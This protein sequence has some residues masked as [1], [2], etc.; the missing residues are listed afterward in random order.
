MN[1]EAPNCHPIS[2]ILRSL[3]KWLAGLA[4]VALV[5]AVYY[6]WGDQLTLANL[7]QHEQQ[8]RQYHREHPALVYITA[9]SVYVLITGLSIP[10][11]T[12]M[13][14]AMAWYFRFWRAL[15]LVSFA[16]TAGATV[17]FL[18]SRYLFRE[19]VQRRFG[20]RCTAFHIALQ[21]EGAFY[22]FTLRLIP[23]VPFFVINIVM[24]L[25]PLRTRTFWWVSQLGMLPGTIVY[26]Y[27]GA[28]APNL[29]T[30]ANKGMQ[31][32]PWLQLGIAS[33]LLGITPLVLKKIVEAVRGSVPS[34][35]A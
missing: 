30:L 18:L 2:K 13:S 12:A 19:A 29:Q 3:K 33:A 9:F 14:L 17:A 23:A 7:A 10:G 4:L 32:V 34:D 20:N 6:L 35:P 22:L 21:R 31:G 8:L 26:T 15:L 27:V 11:A 24:G 1:F 25:T 5:G 16:S 28:S